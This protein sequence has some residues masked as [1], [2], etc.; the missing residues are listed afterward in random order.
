VSTAE[1]VVAD[2]TQRAG[3]GVILRIRF[4]KKWSRSWSVHGDQ[5]RGAVRSSMASPAAATLEWR[6]RSKEVLRGA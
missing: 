2:E 1:G 5:D 3:S 6:W 4:M